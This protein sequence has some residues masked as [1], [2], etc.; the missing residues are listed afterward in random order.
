MF[1]IALSLG[2]QI[3]N[4]FDMS[5]CL[6]IDKLMKTVVSPSDVSMCRM[7]EGTEKGSVE[8]IGSA[9][10]STFFR[11][12][13]VCAKQPPCMTPCGLTHVTQRQALATDRTLGSY[14]VIT[15]P[16][17]IVYE[18]EVETAP[19]VIVRMKAVGSALK[20]EKASLS[21][22]VREDDE[23]TEGSESGESQEDEGGEEVEGDDEH[24]SDTQEAVALQGQIDDAD[25][26]QAMKKLR[27]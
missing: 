7:C 5:M 11:L 4:Q 1:V 22:C 3:N 24:Q 16:H 27:K 13:Q 21:L 20:S 12:H 17:I 23:S 9:T 15:L 2:N 25:A 26:Q 6:E 19:H 18:A 8:F 10:I 14:S